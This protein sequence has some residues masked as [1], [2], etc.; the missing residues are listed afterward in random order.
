MGDT[1]TPVWPNSRSSMRLSLTRRNSCGA[2]H[3][4]HPISLVKIQL[5]GWRRDLQA[6]IRRYLVGERLAHPQVLQ[7][8]RAAHDGDT[9]VSGMANRV[10]RDL[11]CL[12]V[13]GQDDRNLD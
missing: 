5:R 6:W 9:R 2:R 4:A 8:E 1:R 12:A 3:R 11:H 10:Q 13:G 7:I